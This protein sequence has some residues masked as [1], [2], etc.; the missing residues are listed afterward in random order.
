MFQARTNVDSSR[1]TEDNQPRERF[2]RF[3][4]CSEAR[5]ATSLANEIIRELKSLNVY[6]LLLVAQS[7]D[8]ASV[9]QGKHN[10]VQMQ[11]RFTVWL[12]E[13]IS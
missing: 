13:S 12:I 1:Y 6:G 5:D 7:Y 9:M 3:V 2:I 11:N 4:D 10:G 8:G